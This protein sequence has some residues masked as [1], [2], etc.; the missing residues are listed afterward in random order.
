MSRNRLNL[1]RREVRIWDLNDTEDRKPLGGLR[2]AHSIT[3][4]DFCQMLDIILITSADVVIQNEHGDEVLRDDQPLLPG[5]YIVVA[6][7]VDVSFH[8]N[9]ALISL[10]IIF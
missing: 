3:N 1:L 7:E 5:D 8:S 10:S 6:D 2:H 9:V 4:K